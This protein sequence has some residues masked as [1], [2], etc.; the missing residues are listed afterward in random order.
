MEEQDWRIWLA[1]L[2]WDQRN[3]FIEAIEIL[4]SFDTFKK[5]FA[6]IFKLK[7]FAKELRG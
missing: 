1:N 5:E 2:D 4:E 3:K 6:E 7:E